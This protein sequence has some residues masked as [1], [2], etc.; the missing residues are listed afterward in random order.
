MPLENEGGF[1]CDLLVCKC[2]E[3]QCL[4]LP[5]HTPSWPCSAFVGGL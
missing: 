4:C 2:R 5:A 3:N 1:S